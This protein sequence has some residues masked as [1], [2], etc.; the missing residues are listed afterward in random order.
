MENIDNKRKLQ[1]LSALIILNWL[2]FIGIIIFIFNNLIPENDILSSN[3]EQLVKIISDYETINKKWLSYWDFLNSVSDK[4]LRNF[5][6]NS[7]LNSFDENFKNNSSSDYINFLKIKENEINKLRKT[8]NLILREEKLSNV[9]PKYQEWSWFDWNITSLEII[10]YIENLLR[11]FNLS[12]ENAIWIND[13]VLL[14]DKNWNKKNNLSSKLFYIPFSLDLKWTKSDILDFIYFTENIWKIKSLNDD[15]IIFYDDNILSNKKIL[16]SSNIY[17]NKIF[18]INEIALNKYIDTSSSIRSL[19]T[20]KTALWFFYFIKN[21]VEKNDDLN[22]SLKLRFYVRW[23]PKYSMISSL[24][25]LSDK[26]DKLNKD[27]NKTINWL[28][29]EANIKNKDLHYDK[30]NNL[31]K[32]K[33]YI[34]WLSKDF[35]DIKTQIKKWD[36]LEI[37][38]KNYN[39]LNN[40]V[41]SLN[42]KYKNIIK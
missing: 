23:L 37:L 8:N 19:E 20:Q 38:Y 39:N 31:E 5:I 10:N 14:D 22:A 34:D 7:W 28:K 35:S 1:W 17:E 32:I 40:Q 42:E 15:K 33:E 25:N 4:D 12:S 36:N 24:K 3:K 21:W 16:N 2:I 30:I 29:S 6:N 9:L 18:T 13:L 41:N 11:A 27:I 26:Y